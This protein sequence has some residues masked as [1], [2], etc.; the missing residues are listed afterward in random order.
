MRISIISLLFVFISSVAFAKG[1]AEVRDLFK[2]YDQV[3][4]KQEVKLIDE[5]FSKKFIKTSGG[6]KELIEKINGL[7]TPNKSAS[8]PPSEV[9][10]K[11]GLKGEIYFVKM[12]E[13]T[14]AQKITHGTHEAEF[15]VVEEDGKLKIDGTISDGN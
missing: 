12:K 2:K 4:D 5:V 3:M 10:W 7:A 9:T 8:T 1:D 14:T 6:K 15:I 13:P 11:K